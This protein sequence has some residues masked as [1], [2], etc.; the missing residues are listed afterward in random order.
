MASS[1]SSAP[2][3]ATSSEL[4]AILGISALIASVL[5]YTQTPKAVNATKAAKE[6]K[7]VNA[8]SAPVAQKSPVARKEPFVAAGHRPAQWELGGTAPGWTSG[9]WL[10]GGDFRHFWDAEHPFRKQPTY[11]GHPKGL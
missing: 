4:L 1:V 5:I 8:T 11:A 3:S 2:A 6:T 7:A 10:G 9:R